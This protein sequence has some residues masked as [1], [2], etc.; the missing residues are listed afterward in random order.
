MR[1]FAVVLILVAASCGGDDAADTT[2]APATTTAVTAPATTTTVP[3]TTTPSTSSTTSSTTTT[4]T[5]L[6]TGFV[7]YSHPLFTLSYPETWAD[8]PE[9]PG[10]GAGFMEDHTALALP[11]T[12]FSVSLEEQEADFDL[13]EHVL[14]LQDD[15]AFFV[16]D[17]RVL[18]S[19]ER[20]VDGT[21]SLWFEYAEDFDGFPIVI[22]EEVAL[23]ENL[24]VSFTLISPVEFFEF[25]TGQAVQVIDGFRFA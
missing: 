5:S 23:R 20:D 7:A 10:F 25:D 24:L 13:D 22:R 21:R 18:H 1:R 16:P 19:G 4:S 3:P 12:R 17:F 2:V 14:R 9:F 15:L 8:N 6:P 11:A